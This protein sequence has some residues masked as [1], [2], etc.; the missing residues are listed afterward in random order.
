[1]PTPR[2]L[3]DEEAQAIIAKVQAGETSLHAEARRIGCVGGVVR[4]AIVR[5]A[6]KEVYAS[7][8]RWGWKLD[9]Q[10]LAV[11]EAQAL[12][13]VA[14]LKTRTT[15]LR[16]EAQRLNV[17][18]CTLW[19]ALRHYVGE[20]TYR[21]LQLGSAP[22][23]AAHEVPALV[24]RLRGGGSV[25]AEM[26]RY[27]CDYHVVRRVVLRAIGREGYAE[28]V[29]GR[30]RASVAKIGKS[31]TH[32]E[33]KELKA[34]PPPR[35]VRPPKERKPP[36]I[37]TPRPKPPRSQVEKSTEKSPRKSEPSDLRVQSSGPVNSVPSRSCAELPPV[38]DSELEECIREAEGYSS[39]YATKVG[40]LS[41]Q[42]LQAIAQR[43][44]SGAEDCS[45]ELEAKRVTTN[46]LAVA[47][48][49]RR[50]IELLGEKGWQ[51][52]IITRIRNRKGNVR[53]LTASA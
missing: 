45:L 19:N 47:E 15:T 34:A 38:L 32:E 10:L 29:E 20:D 12:E 49:K 26:K 51:N 50:L 52:V 35:P 13:A 40:Q 41:G 30:R 21:G 28:L 7:L 14:R 16:S 1:M 24:A 3:S 43:I 5:T 23:I 48:L 6:G 53:R 2:R 33:T 42:Q 17:T 9:G 22:K 36:R 37:R 18:G 46:P 25:T 8:S 11:T 44:E 39:T 31:E 27:G 4:N